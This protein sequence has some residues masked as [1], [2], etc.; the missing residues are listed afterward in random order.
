[1]TSLFSET[2][3]FFCFSFNKRSPKDAARKTEFFCIRY[4]SKTKRKSTKKITEPCF[5]CQNKSVC[6]KLAWS[7]KKWKSAKKAIY[8]LFAGKPSIVRVQFNKARAL[9]IKWNRFGKPVSFDQ[10]FGRRLHQTTS[11]KPAEVSLLSFQFV[12]SWETSASREEL[13]RN[14]LAYFVHVCELVAKP[15]TMAENQCQFLVHSRLSHRSCPS[16]YC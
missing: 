6:Q 7:C 15:A 14:P 11:W 13:V 3:G 12:S 4:F 8:A 9:H 10:K 1:M 5:A 2:K 16:V